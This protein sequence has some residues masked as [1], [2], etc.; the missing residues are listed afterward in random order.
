[1]AWVASVAK[2]LTTDAFAWR[3]ILL[4]VIIDKDE[5]TSAA[6]CRTAVASLAKTVLLLAPPAPRVVLR[7]LARTH[8]PQAPNLN[9]HHQADGV[10]EAV[11][12]MDSFVDGLRAWDGRRSARAA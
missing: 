7:V 12:V 9:A 6:V 1:M 8:H 11:H 5:S 2:W 3:H 4:L 10:D